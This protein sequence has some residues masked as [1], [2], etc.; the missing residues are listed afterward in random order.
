MN[1]RDEARPA[2]NQNGLSLLMI[3][4]SIPPRIQSANRQ[5]SGGRG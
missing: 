4:K 3:L 1:E 5:G 2:A